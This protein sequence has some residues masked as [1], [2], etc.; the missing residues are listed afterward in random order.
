MHSSIRHL[1][2]LQPNEITGTKIFRG[3]VE[4]PVPLPDLPHDQSSKNDDSP[5]NI[6]EDAAADAATCSSSDTCTTNNTSPTLSSLQPLLEKGMV[7]ISSSYKQCVFF[8]LNFVSTNRNQNISYNFTKQTVL[9]ERAWPEGKGRFPPLAAARKV[10]YLF[11]DLS[12][13]R[14][15]TTILVSNNNVNK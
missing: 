2:G 9:L 3:T 13:S 14:P 5:E 8:V 1:L 15:K 12:F 7:P 4:I 10:I 11:R 6:S